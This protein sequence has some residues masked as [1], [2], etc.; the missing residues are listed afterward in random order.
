MDSRREAEAARKTAREAAQASHREREK[1]ERDREELQRSQEA[2]AHWTGWVNGLR[3]GDEV[4]LR[5]LNRSAKVVRMQLHKQTA[6]VTAG[7]MDIE[8]ALRDLEMPRAAP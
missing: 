4:H 5:T 1:Y 3:P 6:L 7:A 2:F 8:I